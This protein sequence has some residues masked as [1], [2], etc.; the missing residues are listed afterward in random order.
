MANCKTDLPGVCANHNEWLQDKLWD[1]GFGKDGW[2]G[3]AHQK[4]ESSFVQYPSCVGPQGLLSK[5]V[6][7]NRP[8]VLDASTSKADLID[9]VQTFAREAAAWSAK[10]IAVAECLQKTSNSCSVSASHLKDLKKLLPDV[11]ATPSLHVLLRVKRICGLST[12]WARS[13]NRFGKKFSEWELALCACVG[14]PPIIRQISPPPWPPWQ[15]FKD[16]D[17]DEP[18]GLVAFS[19]EEDGPDASNG[20]ANA[21]SQMTLGLLAEVNA[22]ITSRDAAGTKLFPAGINE[23]DAEV[24]ITGVGKIHLVLKGPG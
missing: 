5:V 15:G 6:L 3:D 24:E 19:D 12:K 22:L 23:I 7:P 14:C 21:M 1:A 11:A 13:F 10:I 4:L 17:V 16:D 9:V 2:F 20:S 8:D 18:P